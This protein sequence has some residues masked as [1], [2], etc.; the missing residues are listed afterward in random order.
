MMNGIAA[1]RSL[2]AI[3]GT[4]VSDEARARWIPSTRARGKST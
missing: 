3:K 1:A 2:R 4:F